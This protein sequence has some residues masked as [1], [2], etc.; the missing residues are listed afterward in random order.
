MVLS[1]PALIGSYSTVG[2]SGSRSSVPSGCSDVAG[3]VRPGAVVA[4]GCARGVDAFFRSQFP[5]SSVF[6]AR[7]FG[8]G[9]SSFARRSI[10]F[11]GF[12]QSSGGLLVSFPGGPCPVGLLPSASSSACFSGL[13]SGS[14]ATLALALGLGVPSVVCC[15]SSWLPSAWAWGWGVS[16]VSELAFPG[17][18][19][20]P[21]A[22]G[23]APAAS[24]LA[25]F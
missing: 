25:L 1:L 9:R 7:E 12:L 8:R 4:V 19:A 23:V 11:V 18:F 2:F 15:E 6:V 22:R 16:P 21:A 3:L 24:Q 17:F 10:A 20:C 13:G 5:W 14:W